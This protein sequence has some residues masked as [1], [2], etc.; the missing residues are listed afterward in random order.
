[1]ALSLDDKLLGEKTHYYCSSSEDEGDDGNDSGDEGRSKNAEPKQPT[2]IPEP[3]LEKYKGYCT[4][5]GPKGVINDWRR[6]KQLENEKRDDQEREKFELMKKLSTTCRTEADDQKEK[7][8][9]AKLLEEL[10]ELEDEFLKEYR[11]KRLEEMRKITENVPKFGKVTQLSKES[12]V[13]AIDKESP[14][15]TVIIHIYEE[16][17]PACTAMNGC[18]M[19]LAQEYP[20]VKFCRLKASD[21]QLSASFAKKGVPALLVYKGGEMIGNFVGLANEFGIDFYA[22][23]VEG[24]L[25]EHGMLPDKALQPMSSIRGPIQ[26]ANKDESDDDCEFD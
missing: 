5:T 3:E 24:F 14:N 21:S 7:E 8:A 1:M 20:V 11:L 10:G 17:N 25:I 9:D 22:N 19:C 26:G 23:D 4:N 15:V 13:D 16:Y 12:F 2:F 18:V 6:Y